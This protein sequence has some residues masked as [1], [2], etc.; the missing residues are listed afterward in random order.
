VAQGVSPEF[1]PQYHTHTKKGPQ[2]DLTEGPIGPFKIIKGPL[3]ILRALFCSSLIE[4]L[5]YRRVQ[6][7]A[8]VSIAFF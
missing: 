5:R 2:K 7:K 1:K 6:F 8:F 4:N 3:R